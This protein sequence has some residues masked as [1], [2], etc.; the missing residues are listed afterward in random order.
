MTLTKITA[1]HIAIFLPYSVATICLILR[2][3]SRR[4]NHSAFWLDDYFAV[5][6]WVSRDIG[7][8]I[9][10]SSDQA[11]GFCDGMEYHFNDM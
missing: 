2:I 11:R 8:T 9:L 5:A 3:L 1:T 6:A 7:L 10:L 4:L